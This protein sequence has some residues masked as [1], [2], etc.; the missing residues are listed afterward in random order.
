MC[1]GAFFFSQG[2]DHLIKIVLW[3]EEQF[4][5]EWGALATDKAC[6]AQGRIVAVGKSLKRLFAAEL[7]A[8]RNNSI[9][10]MV[11]QRGRMMHVGICQML[12]GEPAQD[13]GVVCTQHSFAEEQMWKFCNS[14]QKALNQLQTRDKCCGCSLRPSP[15]SAYLFIS[16][17][18]FGSP[19]SLRRELL[20][21]ALDL[22]H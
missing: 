2:R 10:L 16:N 4:N 22:K 18:G 1:L 8:V 5:T 20:W 11:F 14:H 13:A 9:V 15:R 3:K 19:D 6:T 17:N 7:G 21:E 12:L